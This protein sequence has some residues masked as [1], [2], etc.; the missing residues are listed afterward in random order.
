MYHQI[1]EKCKLNKATLVA[2]SKTK[3]I[4]EIMPIYHLGQRDF[5]EN[6]VQEMVDKHEAMPKDIKWHQIGTLQTNKVK[7]IAPFIHLIHSVE[8]L[9][10]L[11]EIDKQAAKKGRII[12]ILLQLKIAEEETKNGG[13]EED[14]TKMLTYI[15]AG[16]AQNVKLCG[17]MGMATFTEDQSQIRSEFKWLHSKL[18]EI[19]SDYYDA[20][21]FNTLSMGM[22][23]DYEL[24]LEEGS[25]MVRVGSLIFGVRG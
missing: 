3:T 5:G 13:S 22:S 18:Y 17:L 10:L 7:Y 25:N 12:N 21:E 9:S 1:L 6:R 19:K 11:K 8:K 2:V 4:E 16:R 20:P 14:L 23:G 24:A 15:K